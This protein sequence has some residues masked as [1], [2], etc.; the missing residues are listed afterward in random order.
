MRRRFA[1]YSI[2]P[3]I[4]FASQIGKSFHDGA[5]AIDFRET[6]KPVPAG[7]GGNGAS[8]GYKRHQK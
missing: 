5:Y 4:P 8:G 3:I 1:P 2:L 6:K 7:T